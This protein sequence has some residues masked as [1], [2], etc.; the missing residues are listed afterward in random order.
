MKLIYLLIFFLTINSFSQDYRLIHKAEKIL[1]SEKSNFEKVEKLLKRAKVAD[2]GFCGNA[3]ITAISEIDFLN[4]KMYYLKSEF[5]ECI[6]K[7]DSVETWER[8]KSSDSLKVLCLTKLYGKSKIK[9]LILINSNKTI[10]RKDNFRYENI[11]IELK[12]INYTFCFKDQNEE[13]N[14]KKE[15]TLLEI[16]KETNFYKILIE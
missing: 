3:Y 2:Y 13:F 12:E 11:C 15:L 8:Q 14:Y 5:A 7:I 9:E 6:K 10:V 4:A 16:I 1:N